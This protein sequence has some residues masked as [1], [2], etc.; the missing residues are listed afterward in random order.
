LD[1]NRAA[2]IPV[3]TVR[4][5]KKTLERTLVQPGSIKPW[6][7]AEL[8][9]KVSGYLKTIQ[10]APSPQMAA[11]IVAQRLSATGPSIACAAHLAGAAKLALWQAPQKDIGAPVTAGELLLEIATPERLQ[12]I[13]EKESLLHQRQAELE[14]ARTALATFEAAVQATKAH[15]VQA[16]ADVRKSASEHAFRTKELNRLKQLVQSRTIT[17]EIADEKQYQVNAA[18]AAWESSQAKVQTAQADLA[19]ASS[20]WATA[21]ADIKVKEA[22]V[23]VAEEELRRARILADYS[24]VYAPFDGI[25]TYRG[26]DEGDFVQNATSG[27]ARRLMTVTAVNKVKVVLQVPERDAPW[28]QVGTQAT[29]AVDARTSW[30]FQGRV[31]RTAGLLEAQTRTLQVE[32]DCANQDHQ[33]LSDMYGRVTLTL[34]RIPNAQAIPATAVYSRTGESFILQVRDGV[35]HRQRVRIRFDDGK[36]VEVV[37]LI[38]AQEVLLDGSEELIVSNKGEIAEAQRVKATPLTGD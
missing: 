13:V 31:A 33:L 32:I 27:Q 30:H 11:D 16:E 12:E 18:L 14:A 15:L 21:R 2:A 4:P 38:G 37:K 5:H 36:Q 22:L 20:K 35:A 29:V 8:Y 24:N 10:R 17:E 26:V 23:Q 1:E 3:N 7:Q 28:V 25:I 6:A 9:A 19:V 34:Q